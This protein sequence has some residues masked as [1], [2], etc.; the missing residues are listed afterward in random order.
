MTQDSLSTEL[1]KKIEQLSMKDRMDLINGINLKAAKI[2]QRLFPES[3]FIASL[4][5]Q[6]GG[7]EINGRII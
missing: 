7:K 3:K 5:K 2:A 1:D 6:K 4:A